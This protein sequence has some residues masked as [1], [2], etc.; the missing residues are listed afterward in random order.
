MTKV[1]KWAFLKRDEAERFVATLGGKLA[2]YEEA[3]GLAVQE[4]MH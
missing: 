2:T 4:P 3:F 1:A